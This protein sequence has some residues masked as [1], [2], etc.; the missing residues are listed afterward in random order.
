[1]HK[2]ANLLI[3]R[4]VEPH[5]GGRATDAAV[6]FGDRNRPARLAF[7]LV[8]ESLWNPRCE[9]EHGAM[10]ALRSSRICGIFAPKPHEERK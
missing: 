5:R 6:H 8:E 3:T 7:D 4:P 2:N 10:V 9:G 1:V